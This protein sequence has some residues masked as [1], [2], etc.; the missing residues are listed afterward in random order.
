M[1]LADVQA[2]LAH[3]PELQAEIE[4]AAR[5]GLEALRTPK[6]MRLSAWMAEHFYLSEE[7]SYEKGRWVAYP[8]QVAIADCIGMDEISHITLKKSA[9]VGYTK[10]FL[11]AVCYFAEH[12]RRNQAVYQ[13]TDEDRDD[14]VTT[15]L[16][17]VLRDVKAMRHVFP[18]FNRKSKDNTIRKKRFI[19]CLLHLRGAKA[20]KN[21][22]RITVDNVYY[23]EAD[24]FDNDIEKEG[25]PFKLGDKRIEGATFPKSVAGSTPKIKGF[26]LIEAREAE[27]DERFRY[28]VPCPHCKEEHALEW[29]GKD[30]A[31]GFKWRDGD[32]ATAAHVCPHCGTWVSQAEYLAHWHGRWISETGLWIDE[33][34]PETL[35][36]RLPDG[37]EVPPPRHVAFHVWTAYSPQAT[38]ESIARDFLAAARKAKAGDDS[39]LKTFINTTRGETYQVELERTD[40]NELERRAEDYPLRVVPRGGAALTAGVDVQGDRWEVTIWAWG[41]GE[42]SWVVDYAV[43]YGNPA[44]E[45][46]WDAKLLPYLQSP[47]RHLNGMPMKIEAAAIDTGGHCTHQ[48]YNFVRNHPRDRFF[49]IK[50]DSAEGKPIKGRS[51]LQDVNVH[52]RVVKRGVK[53]WLVGTDTAKD[54]LYGRLQVKQPGPGYVHF[55]KHLPAEFFKGLTCEARVPVKVAGGERYRWIKPAG[56]RNEPLDCTVY[57]MFGAHALDLHKY[58]DRMWQRLETAYEADLFEQAPT[59][60]PISPPA[61]QTS[62]PS[63]PP[64][65]SAAPTHRQTPAAPARPSGGSQFQRE[66]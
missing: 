54:L 37:T 65:A 40:A 12:K 36:F 27:A 35:R 57:A 38:W 17:P 53:L 64:P 22:R 7:S 1:N 3:S 66:W 26:S 52:G 21:F 47:L 61:V 16:E 55:S 59:S 25:S 33:S 9:R 29:G 49:A 39:D 30:V 34:D 43:L 14:F 13:P 8:F 60:L 56:A 19:G 18:R 2:V 15:E 42:E 48:A 63:A 58:T 41:R 11:A 10:I 20:A 45:R 50:G 62:A 5:R 28:H 44:V 46:E 51:S 31:H 23:D 32:P 4:A 6:P 24:G